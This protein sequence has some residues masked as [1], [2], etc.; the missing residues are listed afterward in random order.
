MVV[1][2]LECHV[3]HQ[4]I[5]QLVSKSVRKVANQSDSHIYEY[6]WSGKQ[7]VNQ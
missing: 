5:T 6:N 7:S 3:V 4:L 2:Q 1:N